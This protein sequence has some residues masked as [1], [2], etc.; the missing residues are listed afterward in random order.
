MSHFSHSDI[1]IVKQYFGLSLSE[2]SETVTAS[3]TIADIGGLM[4]VLV[5]SH[6][7]YGNHGC[8]LQGRTAVDPCGGRW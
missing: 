2:A 3:T 8:R 6:R 5:V 4:G 7:V 1:W